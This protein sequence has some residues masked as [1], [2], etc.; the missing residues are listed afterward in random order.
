MSFAA[1][2]FSDSDTKGISTKKQPLKVTHFNDPSGIDSYHI[3]NSNI[4]PTFESYFKISRTV[5][6]MNTVTH[7]VYSICNKGLAQC[8]VTEVVKIMTGLMSV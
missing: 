6:F 1:V 4:A 8:V 7:R 3:P 5:H 2:A